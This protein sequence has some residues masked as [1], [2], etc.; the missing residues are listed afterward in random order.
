MKE[1]LEKME[2]AAQAQRELEAA[3]A[4]TM[5]RDCSG[6]LLQNETFDELACG[7][8]VKYE[9]Q[10][11]NI[12]PHVLSFE[13]GGYKFHARYSDYELL[14]KYGVEARQTDEIKEAI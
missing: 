9:Y 1:L 11:G 10:D 6:A 3:G 2:K 14:K 7:Q 4:L 12:F 8:K 13:A 5:V